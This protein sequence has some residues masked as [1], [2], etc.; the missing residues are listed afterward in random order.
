MSQAML[1]RV[2]HTTDNLDEKV[3]RI[4]T[5]MSFLTVGA[6]ILFTSFLT[7]KLLFEVDGVDIVP[8]LFI[9]FVV[10]VAVS[11]AYMLQ[12]MGPKIGFGPREQLSGKGILTPRPTGYADKIVSMDEKAWGEYFRGMQLKELYE[13]WF[14]EGMDEV[15]ALSKRIERKVSQMRRAQGAF[16]TAIVFLI[17]MVLVAV[18]PIL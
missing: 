3:G 7:N 18:S 8:L 12:A 15:Y 13:S 10:S 2:I 9:G 17:V 14:H 16:V 4:F 11:T 5:S 1:D 6:T